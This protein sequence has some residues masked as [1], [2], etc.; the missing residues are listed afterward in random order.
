MPKCLE[1]KKNFH[2]CSNC[3][4]DEY[5][6]M[7]YCSKEC[8]HKSEFFKNGKKLFYQF[9]QSLDSHQRSLYRSLNGPYYN[10]F[11]KYGDIWEEQFNNAKKEENKR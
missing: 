4:F 5:M 6:D 8:L 7:G 2:Y 10:L 1:C 9:Y 3:E 11:E